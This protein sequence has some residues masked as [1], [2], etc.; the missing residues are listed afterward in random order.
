MNLAKVRRTRTAVARYYTAKVRTHGPTPW[1]VDW[2]CGLTQDL[3]F[4]QLL[5]ICGRRRRFSLNDLGCGYAALLSFITQRYGAGQVDYA[6]ADISRLMIE[7]ALQAWGRQPFAQFAVSSRLPRVADFSV[8]SGLF[9]VQLKQ[10]DEAWVAFIEEVL[11]ELH[12]ASRIG[13]AVN[14]ILPPAPGLEPLAGLYRTAPD[15]WVDYCSQAFRAD[16][17]VVKDY[18]LREFTLL[19]RR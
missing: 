1:G 12:R 19:V 11:A 10:T 17:D 9:N 6:G 2:T 8:A 16:V 15:P 5:K 18:G 14:F 7:H 4:V 3:R 13:F